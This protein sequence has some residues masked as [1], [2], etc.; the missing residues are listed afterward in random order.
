MGTIIRRKR[1][2]SRAQIGPYRRHELLTGT[3]YYPAMAYSGYGD[4]TSTDV[5]DFV[6]DEMR[7]DW[8]QNRDELIAFW[9]SGAFT[10]TKY[11]PDSLPWLFVR[12]DPHSLP[13]ASKVL[14][15]SNP[16]STLKRLAPQS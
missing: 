14:D 5:N 12:G 9:K 6:S 2:M 1:L 8:E 13:W 11:F 15:A 16:R 7:L 10:A 4:G 3:I